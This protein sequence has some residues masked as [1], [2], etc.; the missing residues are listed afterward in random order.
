MIKES[1]RGFRENN[2]RN[3]LTDQNVL[4]KLN[5]DLFAEK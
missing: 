5:F 3:D 1:I 2:F 4:T